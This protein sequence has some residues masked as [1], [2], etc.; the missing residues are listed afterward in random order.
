MKKKSTSK[1][2]P[3][4]TMKQ[5]LLVLNRFFN[6]NLVGVKEH[7]KLWDLFSALRGPD[8]ENENVKLATT[9]IIRQKAFPGLSVREIQT[10]S[11]NVAAVKVRLGLAGGAWH[12]PHPAENAFR[13]LGLTW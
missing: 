3:L 9:A 11:D 10:G 2:K 4:K 7:E 12:F 6:D 8:S 1:P 13:A 5:V